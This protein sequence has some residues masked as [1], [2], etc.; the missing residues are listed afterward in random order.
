MTSAIMRIYRKNYGAAVFKNVFIRTGI[1]A[2]IA[3]A[4]EYLQTLGYKT[5]ESVI[6]RTTI[7]V[8]GDDDG[9]IH[10][11]YCSDWRDD[12]GRNHEWYTEIYVPSS[13]N[14]GHTL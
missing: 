8:Y 5:T 7:I 2:S 1:L 4:I 10:E 13:F 6:S 14:I 12:D 11:S 3:R 9:S